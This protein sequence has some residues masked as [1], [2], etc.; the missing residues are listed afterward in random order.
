MHLGPPYL[1]PKPQ[2]T[3][4]YVCQSEEPTLHVHKNGVAFSE[5]AQSG[6][7][8][9]RVRTVFLKGSKEGKLS[10]QTRTQSSMLVQQ[11]VFR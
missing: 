10:A 11:N 3:K 7:C 4:E 8:I 1:A 2:I 6:D 9:Y 5:A